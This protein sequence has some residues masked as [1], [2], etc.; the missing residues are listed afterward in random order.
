MQDV[1]NSISRNFGSVFES[2]MLWLDSL[3]ALLPAVGV[4]L[5]VPRELRELRGDDVFLA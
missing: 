3:D 1:A 2:Q 5:Q 4:P